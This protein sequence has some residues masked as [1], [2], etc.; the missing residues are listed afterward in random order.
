MY[1]SNL[2][3]ELNQV[4]GGSRVAIAAVNLGV[5]VV[6]CQR[7]LGRPSVLCHLDQHLLLCYG[8]NLLKNTMV[9]ALVMANL[10]LRHD[11]PSTYYISIF[12]VDLVK[13]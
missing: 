12:L 11:R 10:N 7:G 5:D 1:C 2:N 9:M 13:R 3:G 6:P 8:S 4:R